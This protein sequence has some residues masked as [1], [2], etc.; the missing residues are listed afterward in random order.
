MINSFVVLALG[1]N[2][3]KRRKALR[4]AI[5]M[6]ELETKNESKIYETEA[7]LPNDAPTSWSKKFLNT[8]VSGYTKKTPEELLL[9][10]KNVEKLIGRKQN[11]KRW[12][13]RVIDIDILF[14]ENSII[15][16]KNLLIPHPELHKRKFVLLP[17]QDIIPDYIHPVYNKTVKTLLD[18]LN[19]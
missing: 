6:L 4:S 3:G 15:K 11:Y 10:I 13:P 9:H 14:Y 17:L 2:Q 18:E 16:T 12:S 7:L 1:S 8:T 19:G 5:N